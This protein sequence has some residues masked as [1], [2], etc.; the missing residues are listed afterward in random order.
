MR[1]SVTTGAPQC[2][3]CVQQLWNDHNITL[4]QTATL[5]PPWQTPFVTKARLDPHAPP[6]LEAVAARAGVSRATASRVLRGASNV[7]DDAR[8]SVQA[9]ARELSYSPNQAARTLVTRRSD[10]VAFY[11]DESQDRFFSD[12]FFLGVLRNTQTG[13]A[14]AGLQLVFTVASDPADHARFLHYAAGGHVDGVLLISLHGKDDLP[15]HLEEHGVPT[16]LCGRPLRKAKSLYY[17]DADNLGG[18]A[19]A[20]EHL[21]DSGRQVVATV[22]G[23]QDMCAGQ[24]RL[25]GYLGALADRG[26]A[27]RPELIAQGNFTVAQGYDA[28]K[29]LLADQPDIDGVFAASDL[30]ALGVMRAI[31][32]SGRAVFDD[33]A[34]VGFDDLA[35]SGTGY[36]ALT[37]VRQPTAEIGRTMADVLLQRIAGED[38][39][40]ATVLPVELVRRE[41][42]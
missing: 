21:I 40:R 28:M 13:I 10:S 36:P 2:W 18:A 1:P 12:P 16:V 37:T 14:E 39:T 3:D 4:L 38:P 34:V 32:A 35:D 8:T 7:S 26:R 27:A 31:E 9:A 17:V 22:T 41:T 5:R 15:E 19:R 24:D 23:P 33:V 20:T 25:A 11:V 6:T 29:R 42:A 30:T